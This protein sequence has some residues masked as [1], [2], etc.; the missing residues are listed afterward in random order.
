VIV[1]EIVSRYA[2]RRAVVAAAKATAEGPDDRE[3]VA[4]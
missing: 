4:A 2:Q 1:Y 3:V